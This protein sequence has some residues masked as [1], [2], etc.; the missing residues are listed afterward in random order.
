MSVSTPWRSGPERK[1]E[2]RYQHVSELGDK[3][4]SIRH[5]P[6]H[7]WQ[8]PLSKWLWNVLLLFVVAA[9]VLFLPPMANLFSNPW[10]WWKT[11]PVVSGGANTETAQF[12]ERARIL[13]SSPMTRV[14]NPSQP[15]TPIKV[16]DPIRLQR[17][18]FGN[19][20]PNSWPHRHGSA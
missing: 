3:V 6:R 10:Q 5:T 20:A 19:L 1:P 4:D 7:Y 12:L 16:A 18:P 17:L 14:A 2:L 15:G 9:T 13:A 11:Y 8:P